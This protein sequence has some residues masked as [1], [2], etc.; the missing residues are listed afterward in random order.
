MLISLNPA[1]RII[2][3]APERSIPE[4]KIC[5]FNSCIP[6]MSGM[7]SVPGRDAGV[8]QER[9]FCTEHMVWEI[10]KSFSSTLMM[11]ERKNLAFFAGFPEKFSYKAH[12]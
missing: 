3:F 5:L 1:G 4:R 8:K 7:S 9:L 10:Q 11:P 6:P 2:R 12:R